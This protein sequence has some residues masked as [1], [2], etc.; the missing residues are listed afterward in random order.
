MLRCLD[1]K[2]MVYLYFILRFFIFSAAVCPQCSG[3]VGLF[4][5]FVRGA[6]PDQNKFTS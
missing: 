1:E 5:L 6:T 2:F 3:Y 4:S